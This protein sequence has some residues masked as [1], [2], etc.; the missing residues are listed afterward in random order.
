MRV[1][2]RK[3][4][5]AEFTEDEL[6]VLINASLFDEQREKAAEI[7]ADKY[8]GSGYLSGEEISYQAYEMAP[9]VYGNVGGFSDIE[10]GC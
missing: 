10:W 6:N 8:D 1:W 3:D 5:Y 9:S 7:L 4:A 2:A